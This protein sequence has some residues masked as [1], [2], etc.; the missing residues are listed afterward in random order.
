VAGSGPFSKKNQKLY[1]LEH[2]KRDW[3]LS[4]VGWLLKADENARQTATT[5]VLHPRFGGEP[6]WG[7]C[8][9]VS[10]QGRQERTCFLE[11]K[12]QETLAKLASAFPQRLSLNW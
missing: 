11:K 4:G 7:W 2:Y 10:L 1:E 9:D 8:H 5:H 6:E 12:K 3:H